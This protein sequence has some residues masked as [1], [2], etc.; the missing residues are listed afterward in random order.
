MVSGLVEWAADAGKKATGKLNRDE[1]KKL[2][3]FLTPAPIARFM[4]NRVVSGVSGNSISI[5][6]PAAGT[7]ILAAAAIEALLLRSDLPSDI[8]LTLFE[9]DERLIASLQELA[10]KLVS[11]ADDHGVN[12]TIAIRNEDFLL[13]T[14]AIKQR[15]SVDIV[16]ANPP[17]FKIG[18]DDKRATAHTYA[19]YGQPNI[20][21]LFMAA[22]ANLVSP[23]G[24]WCF[25]TPRSWTNGSYFAGVRKAVLKNLSID[26]FHIFESRADHF[27]E[28]AILQEAMITCASAQSHSH[29]QVLISASDGIRD[30]DQSHLNTLPLS[31]VIGSDDERLITLRTDGA[32]HLS[33]Y[34]AT[35]ETY[36]LRVST[37]PVVAFRAKDFLQERRAKATVPLLWLQHITHM[38]VQ[39]PIQK[40][41]EHI[42]ANAASAWMLVPNS[43]MV[44]MR[45]FSPKED[46][47]RVTAAGYVGGI[48]G[49]VI[50]LEN[51]LNYIYRPGG[52][53]SVEESLGLA[54]FLNSKIVDRHFRAIAGST[55]VNARELRK[56]PLPPIDG[57]IAIG[58][59]CR[60]G[61]SLREID[62]IVERILNLPNNLVAEVA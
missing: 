1:Q 21:G 22:C 17:Y 28:D 38:S 20:Y 32:D 49:K 35:L 42:T 34:T 62:A 26:S 27:V 11:V 30:I 3:Q 59:S 44:I 50:G 60:E 47:R 31:Q 29:G 43:P 8:H 55:Q 19:V 52:G 33:I 7:G 41:R 45:R 53:M 54:A 57:I 24:R 37:G 39:W 4:A 40:K 61:Q 58:A 51:H 9:I 2:G 23:G 25:I 48:P 56:L 16:I 5:L 6:E 12:L 13:S 14:D 10:S 18:A 46:E 15:P 36:G